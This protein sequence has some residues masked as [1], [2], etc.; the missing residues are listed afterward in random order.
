MRTSA[1]PSAMS[2]RFQR[3]RS[4][5]SSRINSPSGVAR[6]SRRD[7]CSSISANNPCASG[8]GI[9][10]HDET[11]EPDR[12]AR[13]IRARGRLAAAGRVAFVEHQ[14][15]HA[16]HALEARRQFVARGHLV[17]NVGVADLGLGAHDALRDGGR[18]REEG[19]GDL[20]GGETAD[21]AQRQRHLRVGRER[22]VAAREDQA[23]TIVFELFLF[24]ERGRLVGEGFGDVGAIFEMFEALVA[25]LL[26]DG[27]EAPR[28]H[29]PRHRI[30]RQ[31]FGRPL[32]H[33]RAKGVVQRFL[34]ALEV[35]EQAD[36]RREDAARILAVDLV[37]LAR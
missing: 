7:S 32:L 26:V 6:V 21:F 3:E 11:A 31:T 35:A 17:G 24:I 16:Q 29:Q 9:E 13:Q 2:A 22:R 30:L 34:G 5:S 10:L 15:H 14:V 19:R 12:F 20:F 18:G 25:P 37:D 36:Q 27:L 28:R 23:Q 1:A 8:S 4:C 33:G